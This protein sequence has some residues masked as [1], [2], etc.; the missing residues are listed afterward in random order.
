MKEIGKALS[1]LAEGLKMLADGFKAISNKVDQ[2]AKGYKG[3][4]TIKAPR[5]S[6][7]KTSRSSKTVK[8]AAGEKTAKKS[9]KPRPPAPDAGKTGLDTIFELIQNSKEGIS[10]S[11]LME[12]TGFDKKK[13][14]NIILKLKKR[15][16]IKALSKGIYTTGQ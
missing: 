5:Q 10:H 15:G 7:P 16:R 6:A 12:M 11:A 4:D 1:I 2:M 14:S 3:A 8:K 9:S 13:V